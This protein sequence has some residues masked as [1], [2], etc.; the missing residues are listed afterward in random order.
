MCHYRNIH[1]IFC[2]SESS[3]TVLLV[4]VQCLVCLYDA[5]RANLCGDAVLLELISFINLSKF[6]ELDIEHKQ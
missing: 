3:V 2:V 1:I 4:T 6:S 5:N